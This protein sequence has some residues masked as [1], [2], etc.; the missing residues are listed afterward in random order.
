MRGG[1]AE[2]QC[3]LGCDGFNVCGAANTIRSKDFLLVHLESHRVRP[4]IRAFQ[5]APFLIGKIDGCPNQDREQKREE[6]A[7]EVRENQ[8]TEGHVLWRLI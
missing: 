2:F 6:L 4:L 3:S 1:A 5:P 7:A 8:V